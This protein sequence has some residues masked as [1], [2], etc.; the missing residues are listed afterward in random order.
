MMAAI[1]IAYMAIIWLVFDKLRLVRLSLPLALLL[2]AVG[3]IFAFFVIVSMNNFHPSSADARVFQRV[4]Q[5]VPHITAP[6]RVL[7]VVAQPN[8]PVK[9]GRRHLHHRSA[10]IPVRRQ[11]PGSGT[12]RGRANRSAAEVLGR[13]GHG[14][15]REGQR[16]A[17]S[18]AGRVRSADRVVREEGH[19]AGDARQ[20]RTQSR[21][22]AA[23]GRGSAGG[24]RS[25]A[26]RLPVQYRQRE[27]G[28]RAGAAAAGAGQVQCRGIDRPRARA[29][30]TRPIS[31][32][33]P[34]R[35]SARRRRWCRSSATATRAISAWSSRPSCRVRICGSTPAITPKS[36]FPMYPGAC[37]SRQGPDD[38]RH[39]QRRTAERQRAVSGSEC[40]GHRALR[41]P[42]PARRRRKAAAARRHA[43]RAP[44]SIPAMCRSPASS[45][46][47]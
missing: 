8:A 35:S 29:T 17:R 9:Q 46:W 10:A 5:V 16:P 15:R 44:P 6:G 7:E 39:R 21:Y 47:R 27:Y 4:V 28:R 37:L 20:G 41:R 42:H 11:A 31:S 18:R 24:G 25:R 1:F 26:A 40:A 14:R 38:D 19:R 12:G 45:A 33:F 32:S 23:G 2:A 34:A 30:A 13:S 43:G 22:G 3:P 36:S